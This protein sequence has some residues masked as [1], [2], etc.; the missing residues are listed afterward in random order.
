M[1]SREVRNVKENLSGILEWDDIDDDTSTFD[2]ITNPQ[3]AFDRNNVTLALLDNSNGKTCVLRL[4]KP[5]YFD[6]T[7]LRC[8]TAIMSGLVTFTITYIDNTTETLTVVSAGILTTLSVP[9]KDLPV[10]AITLA[11]AINMAIEII[12]ISCMV[13]EGGAAGSGGPASAVKEVVAL[14]ACVPTACI[15]GSTNINLT[16]RNAAGELVQRFELHTTNI[17]LSN[18]LSQINWFRVYADAGRTLMIKE[19]VPGAVGN[20]YRDSETILVSNTDGTL[21][22]TIDLSIACNVT[23]AMLGE[24]ML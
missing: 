1:S 8:T 2:A 24:E 20:F 16:F 5:Y 3:N 4:K 23:V 6:Y 11:G 7:Q 14:A 22:V 10:V 17:W 13:E 15:L 18:L 9:L 21:Y 12:D 19:F